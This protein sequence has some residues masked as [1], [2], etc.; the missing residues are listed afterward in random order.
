MATVDI[1]SGLPGR[2][3]GAAAWWWR[4][5]RDDNSAIAA[6]L[7]AV[8]LALLVLPPI[9]YLVYGSLHTTLPNGAAG[10]LT[11]DYFRTLLAEPQLARSALNSCIFAFGSAAVAITFGGVQAWIVERT[12]AP[13]KTFAVVGAFVSLAIPYILYVVAWLFILGPH[14]PLNDLARLVTGSQRPLLD[15][16]SMWGMILVEGLLWTPLAFL[17]LCSTFRA[18]NAAFEEAAMTCGADTLTTVRQIT[19][20]LATPALL[21]L[22]LMVFIRGIE[23]FEVPALVGLSKR[24]NVLTTEIYLS[25]KL[26]ARPDLGR[27]S[28]FAVVLLVAVSVLLYFYGRIARSASRYQ[29]V[30]GKGFRPRQMDLGAGRWI[31]GAVVVINF[32]IVVVLPVLGLLWT[33]LMPYNQGVSWRGFHLMTL[34]NFRTALGSGGM[35]G[36]AENTL[37]LACATATVTVA[38]AALTGWLVARRRRGAWLLDQLATMPLIFPGVVLAVAMMQIFLALPVPIYGTIWMLMIA[39]TVRY[40][41]YGARYAFTGVLQ[42]HREL[43]EAAVASGASPLRQWGAVVLPL[44]APALAAGW[45]FIFLMATRDLS[46]PVLLSGPRSQVVAVQ[47]FDLWT[48]G[49]GTELAAFGLLWT[50]VM[51]VLAVAA[52]VLAERA[53]ISVQGD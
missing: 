40:L 18:A 21:A 2:A 24:I 13:L 34:A 8:V 23:A 45:L 27:A 30:T 7:L 3:P 22:A 38:L 4:A 28:A 31:A 1:A 50:A 53:G 5:W 47:L 51:T 12:N 16:E 9:G 26:Q 25:L 44:I 29:T 35:I 46:M 49:Q 10:A 14:G 43:E 15:V 48:N 20:K 6:A 37:L 41:P 11:L 19:L 17:M 39:F 32:V 33:A 42:I 36:A 52:Y